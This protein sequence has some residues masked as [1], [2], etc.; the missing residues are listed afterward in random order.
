M[1][2]DMQN[3]ID[4]D[5]LPKKSYIYEIYAVINHVG[6]ISIGHYYCYLKKDDI[7]NWVLFDDSEV[8]VFDNELDFDNNAYILFYIKK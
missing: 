8:K 7:K 6:L 1:I 2:L 3:Y 5:I 4:A